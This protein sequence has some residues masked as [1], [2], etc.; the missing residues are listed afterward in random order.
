MAT[1][2]GANTM[3]RNEAAKIY[4]EIR[5]KSGEPSKSFDRL[6]HSMLSNDGEVYADLM[7]GD[8]EPTW[9]PEQW[10]DAARYVVKVYKLKS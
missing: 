6:V 9:T 1:N 10:V 2:K 4:R 8:P 3:T 5:T 7:P